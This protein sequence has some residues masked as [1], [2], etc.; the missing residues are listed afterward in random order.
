MRT[1]GLFL[2]VFCTFIAACDNKGSSTGPVGSAAPPASTPVSL[3]LDASA[4]STAEGGTGAAG[5]DG[6]AR[7]AAGGTSAGSFAGTYTSKQATEPA[8]KKTEDDGKEGVGDG[9]LTLDVAAD[10]TVKGTLDG[11]LGESILSG[12]S[13]GETMAGTVF[14]KTPSPT[15][16]YGTWVLAK[17]DGALAGKI[18]ASRGN[19][20]A[21]READLTL[22]GK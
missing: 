7:A 19:A 5:T 12:T 10:R 1:S 15:S 13:A 11:A 3:V 20:G 22:K 18:I 14:P 17:K 2:A 21:V 4:Q 16:F 6:G 9:T 8:P